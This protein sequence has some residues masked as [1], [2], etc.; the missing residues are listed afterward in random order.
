MYIIILYFVFFMKILRTSYPQTSPQ[1]VFAY[2]IFICDNKI[3]NK[4]MSK[5]LIINK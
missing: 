4:F 5:I 2:K 3:T 1:F